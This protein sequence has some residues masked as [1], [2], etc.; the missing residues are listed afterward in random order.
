MLPTPQITPLERLQV[1]DGLLINAERWQR[2]HNYHRQR[3]NIHYQGLHQ[4]GVICGLGVSLIPTPKDVPSQY[5]DQRWLQ[6]KP[7]IAIDLVGNPIIVPQPIDF[8]LAAEVT[9][10]EPKLIYIVVTYV[11]PETLQRKSTQEYEAETFRIDEKSTPPTPH[12]VE[13]CRILLKPGTEPLANP[14]NVIYPGLNCLDF[15]YRQIARS[16][17]TTVF[18]AAHLQADPTEA[19]Y[20]RDNLSYLMQSVGNLT[21]YLQGEEQVDQLSFP[22]EDPNA[23]ATYDLLFNTGFSPISLSPKQNTILRNYLDAGGVLLLE[24]PTDAIDRLESIMNLTEEWGTPLE[25]LRKLDRHHP[26][27]TQPFL[28]AALP[29][30]NQKPLQILI[31]GGIVVIIGDLSIAWGL[32]EKLTLPRETIRT[33]QELGINILNFAW[34]RRNMT[35]LFQ[36][37]VPPS[38][39]PDALKNVLSKLDL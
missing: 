21:H 36:K 11:D 15:R 23:A 24:S 13:L 18:R 28:F 9:E 6:I 32:D 29:I 12:E 39:K 38:T 20:S 35:Q 19:Q 3:Q 31:A 7:G 1:Q 37:Y 2:S 26:M 14:Q 10:E 25:D 8:H 33:A 22:L 4:P 16:R 5:D 17:P 30:I 34:S 27:R